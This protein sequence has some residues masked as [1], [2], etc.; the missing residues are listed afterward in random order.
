M[1]VSIIELFL[2]G[3]RGKKECRSFFSFYLPL[4]RA[5]YQPIKVNVMILVTG[6]NIVAFAPITHQR[7]EQIECQ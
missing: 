4:K 2:I 5:V 3:S 6:V 7:V 1:R